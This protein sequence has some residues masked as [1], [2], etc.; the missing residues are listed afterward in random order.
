MSDPPVIQQSAWIWLTVSADYVIFIF[1]NV[2]QSV[3]LNNN[4]VHKFQHSFSSEQDFLQT[5]LLLN[6]CESSGVAVMCSV[7]A[8]S[9]FPVI[10]IT[11]FHSKLYFKKKSW[12]NTAAW[13]E[14]ITPGVY[15]SAQ[16]IK[17]LTYELY[18]LCFVLERVWRWHG[19]LCWPYGESDVSDGN[20]MVKIKSFTAALWG[21]ANRRH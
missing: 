16:S 6:V 19:P 9:Q 18:Y 11:L 13:S 10:L 15:I 2:H 4:I 3:L 7:H 21:T 17:Y 12:R 20:T 8:W 5:S 14:D 1:I